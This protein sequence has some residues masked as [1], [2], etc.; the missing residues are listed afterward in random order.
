M[1]L[2][3]FDAGSSLQRSHFYN[4]ESSEDDNMLE[5]QKRRVRKAVTERAKRPEVFKNARTLIAL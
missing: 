4:D 5:R 3:I 2:F 1:F